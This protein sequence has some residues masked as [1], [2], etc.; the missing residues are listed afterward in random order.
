MRQH[1]ND[2]VCQIDACPALLRLHI[3]GGMFLYI[4]A[5]IRNVYA[6]TIIFSF[7]HTGNGIVQIF[8]VFSVDRYHLP[9]SEIP[10]P[11]PVCLADF[12][13][14]TIRLTQ[15]FFGKCC[16]QVKVFDNRENIDPRIVLMTQDLNDFS[17]R[18]F[19]LFSVPRQTDDNLM[20][21]Y[22]AHGVLFGNK[23]ILS[24]FLIVRHD[25]SKR[26]AGFVRT[27]QLFESM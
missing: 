18:L 16:R 5:H 25:K 4:V 14:H 27:C 13:C 15:Q 3:K 19:A 10:A 1:R 26:L 12:L 21:G 24:E 8:G 11:L 20:S 23:N 2:T 6:K 7:H 22:R 9:V 17:F